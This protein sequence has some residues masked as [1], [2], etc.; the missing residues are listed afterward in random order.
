MSFESIYNHSPNDGIN[1]LAKDLFKILRK[2]NKNIL[3]SPV[4]IHSILSQV[5]QGAAGATKEAFMKALYSPVNEKTL[6]DYKYVIDKTNNLRNV[7]YYLAN[8]VYI[9]ESLQLKESFKNILTAS[10]YSAAEPLNFSEPETSA[11]LINSWV[12]NKTNEK[13]KDLVS[14]RDLDS[15]TALVLINAIYFKGNWNKAFDIRETTNEK[16][17]LNKDDFVYVQMMHREGIYYFN[18][19]DHL[20]ANVL[21]LPYSNRYVEM[22]IIYP[23]KKDGLAEMEEKLKEY[24]FTKITECCYS[25]DVKVSIPKFRLETSME[26]TE[27]L[28]EVSY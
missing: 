13:I 1:L 22:V 28:T 3:F 17:Y 24:D 21:I 4:S 7:T 16:F 23:N 18:E 5:A 10:F 12:G 11:Q 6:Q 9:K 14:P 15:S 26:L 25:L 8:K 27:P 2:T 20:D 19:I